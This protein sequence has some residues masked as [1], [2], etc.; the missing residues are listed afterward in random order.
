VHI[1]L[2]VDLIR[3]V[4]PKEPPHTWYQG[5]I[6][7][8]IIGVLSGSIISLSGAAIYRAK[9]WQAHPI[10]R[11][12]LGGLALACA[13][14]ILSVI[15][16]PSAAV[17]PGGGGDHVGREHAGL[18]A[19]RARG[20]SAPRGRYHGFRSGRRMRRP[21]RAIHGDRRSRGTGVRTLTWSTE[22]SCRCGR[23]GGRD[24]RRL[25]FAFDRGRV[26]SRPRWP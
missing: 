5:I 3:L 23:C 12:A 19:Y 7:A 15:A 20:R 16:A 17:G 10:V 9:G 14:V 18:G 1:S 13:A 25:S 22:R 2:G 24:Q 6:T 21:V 8:L 11:L 4:V 26:G